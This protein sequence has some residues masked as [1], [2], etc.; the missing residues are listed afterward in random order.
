MSVAG[1]LKALRERADPKVSVRAMAA[2]L[3]MPPST[4]A[5][6][7]DPKKYKKPILPFDLAQRISAILEERGIPEAET[8]QLAG[9]T[10][11]QADS[12]PS[13]QKIMLKVLGAVAAGVWREQTQW[14]PEEQYEIE[15]GPS[16]VP[17]AERFAVRMDGLSMNRT[18][19]PGSELECLRVMFGNIQPQ[20]G[21]LVI[22]QRN[23][24]D[25]TEMTCK[26]LDRDEEGWILRAESTLP[27]FQE[28]IRLG[29]PDEWLHIDNE[30]QVV[31]IVIKSHQ[32]HFRR[33]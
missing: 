31:G 15:V 18:I 30:I 13:P 20:P 9:L 25:L 4:Y 1:D 3:G 21:D 19:P 5:A 2:A 33:R 17:G 8:M 14:A 28:V 27:E 26:R 6:Y 22:V 29:E 32:D 11:K 24:H 12:P 7:E 16:P 23:S 10:L